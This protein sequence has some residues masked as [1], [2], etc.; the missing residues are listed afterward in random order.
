[1]ATT[2]KAQLL[3]EC[4]PKKSVVYTAIAWGYHIAP[5]MFAIHQP[6]VGLRFLTA[7]DVRRT[8]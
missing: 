4:R 2:V 3:A 7:A 6:G 8:A 5:V 1:M